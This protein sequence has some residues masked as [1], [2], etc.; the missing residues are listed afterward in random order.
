MAHVQAG[1]DVD[2]DGLVEFGGGETA[3]EGD[4]LG[5]LVFTLAIDAGD[6]LQV[7]ASVLGTNEATS[8]P[9]ERAVPAMILAAWSTS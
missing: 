5:G 6:G 4:G 9:I 3:H 8:T 2:L 1:A 7:A